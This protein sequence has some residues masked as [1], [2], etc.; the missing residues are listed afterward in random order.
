M[1]ETATTTMENRLEE[2]RQEHEMDKEKEK[3]FMEEWKKKLRS[4]SDDEKAMTVIN[5]IMEA[6]IHTR[7][8]T[9][10]RLRD[11]EEHI[12]N[13][14]TNVEITEDN[15]REVMVTLLYEATQQIGNIFTDTSVADSNLDLCRKLINKKYPPSV[16]ERILSVPKKFMKTSIRIA[17]LGMVK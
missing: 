9:E 12:R 15:E 13:K 14:V 16:L 17:T 4:L 3:I 1:T 10:K 6:V 5:Q 8:Y 7:A 11:L 2:Y